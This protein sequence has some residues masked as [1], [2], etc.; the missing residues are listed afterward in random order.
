MMSDFDQPLVNQPG[1]G[2]EYGVC[3][4]GHL[5]EFLAYDM[6]HYELILLRSTWIGLEF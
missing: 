5:L 1:E 2:F 6:H 4:H 3:L